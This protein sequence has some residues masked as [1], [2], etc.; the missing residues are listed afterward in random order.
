MTWNFIKPVLIFIPLAVLQLVIAPIISV[1]DTLPNFII[2][3]IV[4]YSLIYGQIFG[5][6]LGFILGG[7]FDL[8]SGSML[9]AHMLSFTIS[10]FIA[11]YFFNLNK[12][13]TNTSTFAFVLIVFL[14]GALNSFLYSAVSISSPDI[15]FIYLLVEEGILPG[16]YTA[17]IS[18]PVVIFNPRKDIQ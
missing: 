3:L 12:I 8:I 15:S 10:A 17:I 4:F 13:D 16:I 11:G 2:V 7:L 18:I 5:T 14:C 1:M 9:G 6:V